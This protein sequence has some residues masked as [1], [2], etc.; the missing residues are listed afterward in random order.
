MKKHNLLTLKEEAA[1]SIKVRDW[2]LL[3]NK[4]TELKEQ[5]GGRAPSSAEW[6][7][8]FGLTEQEFDVRW[9]EGSAVRTVL[10][11]LSWFA[12]E[13]R[14]TSVSWAEFS[15]AMPSMGLYCPVSGVQAPKVLQH[16]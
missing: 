11:R 2:V 15:T 1:L 12:C 7:A 8:G 14:P 5:F 13:M 10:L 6:A 9:R 16:T 3:Q 4:Y